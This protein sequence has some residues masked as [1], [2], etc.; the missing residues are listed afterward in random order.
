MALTYAQAFRIAAPNLLETCYAERFEGF[1]ENSK[2]KMKFDGSSW[3][4]ARRC[5][6]YKYCG[7]GDGQNISNKPE[8][9]KDSEV[10]GPHLMF[11]FCGD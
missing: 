2:N 4:N 1:K 8:S 3:K 6:I 7:F 5:S 10:Q 9:F 11:C